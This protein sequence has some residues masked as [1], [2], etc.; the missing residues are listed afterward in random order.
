MQSKT[1]VHY[2]DSCESDYRLFW[3]LDRSL[4]MHAGYWDK[5]TKTLADALERENAVLAEWANITKNDAVLDAGCGIG[6]SS[7]FLASKVGCKV[8]GIT[9]SE[10]QAATARQQAEKRGVSHLVTFETMDFCR[11]HYPDA[12]FDVVWGLESICHAPDKGAFVQEAYRLLKP[13]GRLVVADGFAKHI[14]DKQ[15]AYKMGKWLN[16]WGVDA[17]EDADQFKA[18]LEHAGFRS[19][20]YR[21]I[22][23]H[24]MPSSKRL[25]WI[26]FPAWVYS[27]AGEWLRLRTAV[28]TDNIRAAYYQYTTLKQGLWEYGVFTAIAP[29]L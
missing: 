10:R 27:K 18:H 22:T 13:G 20:E 3:N 23:S 6:G 16:G 26:S 29:R 12:A 21:D 1:I 19:I 14:E 11:T 9:L 28:Q 4:A 15:D 25:F 7:I 2:Y 8:T 24:V 5:T 17:L